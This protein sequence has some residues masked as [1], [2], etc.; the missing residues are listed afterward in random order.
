[1]AYI[2]VNRDTVA[3]QTIDA[4]G[5]FDKVEAARERLVSLEAEVRAEI[6]ENDGNVDD[7]EIEL[8][9]D[10]LLCG[11]FSWEIIPIHLS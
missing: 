3:D 8:T 2:I 10:R 9:E 11:D 7:I 6:L 1:M 4:I 5:P